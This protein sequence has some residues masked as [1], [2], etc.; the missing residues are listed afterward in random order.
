MKC[1]RYSVEQIVA[2]VK[3]HDLGTLAAEV[4]HK[5]GLPS[6]R[7]TGGRRSTPDSSLARPVSCGSCVRRTRN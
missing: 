3:Q 7:F 4:A 2:A 6:R 1:V 5:L